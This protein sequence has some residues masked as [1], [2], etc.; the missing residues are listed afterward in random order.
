MRLIQ[1][2]NIT[3][4]LC[5]SLLVVGSSCSK[6]DIPEGGNKNAPSNLQ[7]SVE[8]VGTTAATPNGDGSGNVNITV[9]ATNAT[10]YQI[11]LPNQG[12]KTFTLTNPSGGTVSYTFSGTAG[13]TV[14]YPVQA[15]AYNGSVKTSTTTSVTVYFAA[16]KSDVAF[17]LTTPDKTALFQLQN[18]GLNFA[19]ATNANTTI[20]VD[21]SQK[22]QS[23]D[24]FGYALTGGSAQLINQMS[25][26]NKD[27][28][29][30]EL[31]DT[32]GNHIGVSYLRLS[33]GA[34][35]LSPSAFTYDDFP[36]D[37]TLQN[38][39]I[40]METDLIPVLQK[41]IALNPSIKIIATPWS[42]PAWMKTNNNMYG[43]GDN[44]GILKPECYGIYANYF[45]KYIQAMAAQGITINA[46]TPQNEPLN[47]YNN[48]SMLMQATEENNF[49]KNYLAPAFAA[50]G[51][52][53]KIIVYDHNL[54]H[55]EYATTILSD[56]TTY[57]LVDGS[58]FHLYAGNISAMTPV[59]T[60]F[61]DKNLYFT[62]QYTSSTGDFGGDI[63]WHI[64]NVIVGATTNWSK[65]AIEWNL[66][67]DPNQQPH[68]SGGC[69]DC[70][71]AV[72]ISGASVV[73]RNQSYCIIAHVAKFVR[74]GSVRIASTANSSLPNAAF[75][76][77]DGKRVLIVL[78]TNT[79]A[80]VTFNIQF[81][82][83]AVSPT[84]PAGAVGTFVW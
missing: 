55:P 72:T 35:D 11:I 3:A 10:T 81:N 44:P 17:W 62:E 22:F 34:S 38:F 71:G 20:T 31:F 51:I 49:I 66:A 1:K 41:I 14:T 61:P 48:P 42:A 59:H 54:D 64:Q 52:T 36:G 4:L 2:N 56:P 77:P 29:L 68:L 78:N 25:A 6:K 53:A 58:A 82:G 80:S 19:S 67:S 43:G 30:S 26:A 57:N 15:I 84:L 46:I 28:L 24:G 32:S 63:Q 70:L 47:A 60:Q 73:S 21:A 50:N 33:I 16:I 23:I 27:S 45:V 40:G 69:S 8:V 18:V 65:N 76:T 79:S 9:S 37:S 7:V 75:Q 39:S 74:P 13:S 5:F 83:Q 12:N